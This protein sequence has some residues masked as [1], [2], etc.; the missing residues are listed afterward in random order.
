MLSVLPYLQIL[1]FSFIGLKF[2]DN[3]FTFFSTIAETGRLHDELKHSER[4][5]GRKGFQGEEE[6][7]YEV[8]MQ[9]SRDEDQ[10]LLTAEMLEE[11]LTMVQKIKNMKSKT[12]D[13]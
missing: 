11:H 12:F 3:T 1:N 10:N 2:G 4:M 9:V 13:V 8:L 5:T 6:F 7:G